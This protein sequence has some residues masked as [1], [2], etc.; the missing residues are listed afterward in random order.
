MNSEDSFCNAVDR[1]MPR[2]PADVFRIS[3]A[4]GLVTV[5]WHRI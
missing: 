5:M 4:I 1:T 2:M 3:V